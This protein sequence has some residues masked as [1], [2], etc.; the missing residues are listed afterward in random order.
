[1]KTSK[2]QFQPEPQNRVNRT[3]SNGQ[4]PDTNSSDFDHGL[5]QPKSKVR[6]EVTSQ[7]RYRNGKV[8]K[9]LR[10]QVFYRKPLLTHQGKI[11]R[12][13]LALGILLHQ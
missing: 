3:Q 2:P 11:D 13:R 8:D 12:E 10:K 7:W 9:T 1:M 4:L 5:S 6:I